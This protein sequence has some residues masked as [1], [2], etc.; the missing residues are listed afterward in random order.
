MTPRPEFYHLKPTAGAGVEGQAVIAKSDLPLPVCAGCRYA[1][2]EYEQTAVEW[3]SASKFNRAD[4]ETA[5]VA[6]LTLLHHKVLKLIDAEAVAT[7]LILGAV[8]DASGQVKNDWSVCRPRFFT[9]LR[10]SKFASYRYCDRCGRLCY[11]AK[12]T[13]HVNAGQ[14]FPLITGT[15]LGLLM[16]ARVASPLLE[17]KWRKISISPV[18]SITPPP[19]GFAPHLPWR[20]PVVDGSPQF[21][22]ASDEQRPP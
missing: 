10:G 3:H 11:F 1:P 7:C 6:S 13:P 16:H 12:G 8:F 20:V 5:H 2:E 14:S 18:H 22:P 9:A 19:D 17:K 15:C 4:M 21:F